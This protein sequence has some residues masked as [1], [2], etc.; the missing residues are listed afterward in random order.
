MYIGS[1]RQKTKTYRLAKLMKKVLNFF[2]G[3]E[4]LQNISIGFKKYFT[5]SKYILLLSSKNNEVLRKFLNFWQI[6]SLSSRNYKKILN[7]FSGFRVLQINS[8]GSKNYFAASK[9]ILLPL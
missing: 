5:A 6:S 1:F 2:A 9:Y 3:F 8:T 7:F 4:V